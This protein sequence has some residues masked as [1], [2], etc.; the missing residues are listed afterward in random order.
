VN[1]FANLPSGTHLISFQTDKPGLAAKIKSLELSVVYQIDNNFILNV[2]DEQL[3]LLKRTGIDYRILDQSLSGH[4]YHLVNIIDLATNIELQSDVIGTLGD[5]V[6]LKNADIDDLRD[7]SKRIRFS[8]LH[9]STEQTT[10]RNLHIQDQS[11]T[12]IDPLITDLIEDINQDTIEHFISTLQQYETRFMM[13]PNRFEVS[14]WIFDQFTRFG[15]TDV[16]FDTFSAHSVIS[17]AY[18]DEDTVTIQRNV[19]ATLPGSGDEDAI[20]IVCGHYDSFNNYADPFLTAPGA[21]DDA[22]GTAAVLEMARVFMA[23]NI[24]P[25]RTIRFIAMAAEELMNFGDGG[26]KH[27][28]AL[29]DSIDMDIRMV[30]NHD[31]IGHTTQTLTNSTVLVNHHYT[32]DHYAD[33]AMTNIDIYTQINGY[34]S[35]YYGADLGPFIQRGYTG[36][37]F[38]ESEFSPFYHSSNDVIENCSMEYCAEVIKA[39]CATLI[40]CV[41]IP[42][43][44]QTFTITD[45]S[46]GTSLALSWKSSTEYNFDHYKIY[47]GEESGIYTREETT[48]DTSH[49]ID[50][51]ISGTEYYIG[52]SVV[53]SDGYESLVNEQSFIPF[54]F[55]LDQG[56]LV[57]DE[58]TDGD[59][60][61]AK[62][63][64][65]QVDLFYEAVLNT[66]DISHWD[67]IDHQGISLTDFGSYST[68]IWQADDFSNLMTIDSILNELGRFLHAG[69]N[70]L[71]TGYLP[72]QAIAGTFEYPDTFEVG[73]FVYEYLKISATN[74]GF[75]TRFSGANSRSAEYFDIDVDT[76]KIE[77]IPT[78]HLSNI[79]SIE[80]TDQGVPILFYDSGYDSLSVQGR[81]KGEP[82]GIEYIGEDYKVVTLTFPLYFMEEKRSKELLEYIIGVKFSEPMTIAGAT[83]EIPES[84][85]LYQNYPNPFN[86]TTMINYQLSMNNDVELSI[87]NLLGQKIATLVSE[88]QQAG[89]HSVTWD[90]TDMASGVYYYVLNSGDFHDVKKMVLLR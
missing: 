22:S 88:Y 4:S 78:L 66:F 41:T 85:A 89:K 65:E 53:D 30:I 6:I 14:Q 19:V 49:V 72:C 76:N 67:L 28:A 74:K 16:Q 13:A 12:D 3:Q 9:I 86:P 54:Y 44:L 62:P 71:Y 34:L 8:P 70:L 42:T 45:R 63:S 73:D 7:P 60:S 79:E 39:S 43:S 5:Y 21:D 20:F 2:N 69:G 18:V 52:L 56:I 24:T 31:M 58:T 1:I 23:N 33:L 61:L 82:V 36:I 87:Y 55:S 90:A 37:Y 27:Y 29:A 38:E 68:I 46:D 57:I 48:E 40:Q 64:D 11:V 59:G 10:H 25:R 75:G 84:F 17:Y 47:V 80:P 81:M 51:L 77:H 15:F 26:S 50:Q 83:T 35:D 32:S